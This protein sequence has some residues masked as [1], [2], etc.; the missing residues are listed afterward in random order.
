MKLILVSGHEN[1]NILNKIPAVG[2]VLRKAGYLQT[3]EQKEAMH[4]VAKASV[5][6]NK[7]FGEDNVLVC[8][9]WYNL[10]QKID[11]VNKNSTRNDRLLSV[12]LNSSVIPAAH[13]SEVWYYGRSEKSYKKA[14]KMAELLSET[15]GTDDR[16]AK[17]D[18]KD[19]H[20]EG[21]RHGRLG[22]VRDTDPWAFLVELGFM[23]NTIDFSKIRTFG[24]S[25][26]I[27]VARLLMKK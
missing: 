24:V 10:R 3:T 11:W 5:V 21:N 23:S 14:K 2:A 12:H 15:M 7:E 1:R 17:P 22:I 8:P 13:G 26:V 16:G 18:K 4:I 25:G 20:G 9:F 27:E 6:L 19:K